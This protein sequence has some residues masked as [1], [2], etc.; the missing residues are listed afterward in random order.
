SEFKKG[1]WLGK[2]TS[3]QTLVFDTGTPPAI[4]TYQIALKSH[5]AGSNLVIDLYWVNDSRISMAGDIFGRFVLGG[6]GNAVDGYLFGNPSYWHPSRYGPGV[7]NVTILPGPSSGIELY[8]PTD[9]R[10]DG[11]SVVHNDQTTNITFLN[12]QRPRVSLCYTTYQNY[13]GT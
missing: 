12:S 8:V 10:F 7:R 9:S 2:Q 13:Y 1:K 4:N 6:I 11:D 3:P 5:F